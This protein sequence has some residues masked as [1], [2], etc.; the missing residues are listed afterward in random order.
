MPP[1]IRVDRT[2]FERRSRPFRKRV[3][4]A[5][6]I[7]VI[8]IVA[9]SCTPSPPAALLGP[10]PADP[11][12]RVRSVQYRSAI[13]SYKSRRPL[14]PGPWQQQNESVKPNSGQ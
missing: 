6:A 11:N 8:A 3:L 9:G 14:E 5:V 1:H 13:A 2:A 12:V 7:A 10:D 4:P